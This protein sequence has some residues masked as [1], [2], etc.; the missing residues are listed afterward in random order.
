MYRDDEVA[1]AA[2]ANALIDEIADLEREQVV[3]TDRARRLDAA[4]QE[5][6][7]LRPVTGATDEPHAPGLGVH[8]VVL[9]ASAVTAFL[10]Y[11]LLS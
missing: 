3:A 7:E 8:V 6:A 1:G 4:R 9:A 11:S 10:A 5:L 2:R